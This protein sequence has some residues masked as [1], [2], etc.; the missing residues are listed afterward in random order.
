MAYLIILN[1]VSEADH[2]LF[3]YVHEYYKIKTL[4]K[5]YWTEVMLVSHPQDSNILTQ[6]QIMTVNPLVNPGQ[7]GRRRTR[8]IPSIGEACSWSRETRC[9]RFFQIDHNRAH[10]TSN[11][12][13][14]FAPA[15]A[16][17]SN[18]VTQPVPRIQSGLR[19]HGNCREA[20]HTRRFCPTRLIYS[21]EDNGWSG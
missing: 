17:R 5:L 1:H 16:S 6:I 20:G 3:G 14:T 21:S 18:E 11:M 12:P 15:S 4:R 2:S 13:L 19:R 9:S 10:C 7:V 8:R